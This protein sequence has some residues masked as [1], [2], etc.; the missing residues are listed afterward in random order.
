PLAILG[1][2]SPYPTSQLDVFGHDGD[3]FSVDGTE[4]GV[5]KQTHQSANGSTLETEISLE[6]LGYFPH[7]T[8]EWKLADEQ[9]CGLLV[10][11]D[12]P[13]SHSSWPGF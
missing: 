10:T 12:L 1:P 8:L 9:L 5:L 13:Q 2:L 4:V 11:T 6:V 7:Q 3:T